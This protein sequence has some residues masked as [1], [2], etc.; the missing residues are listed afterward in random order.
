MLQHRR[1]YLS[2][3]ITASAHWLILLACSTPV[4]AAGMKFPYTA[5]TTVGD[6]AVHSGPGSRFY[7]TGSLKKAAVVEVH[8]HDPGGWYMIAPPNDSFSLIR[9]EHINK[10]AN[11]TGLVSENNVVV[12]VGSSLSP[13]RH[14]VEQRRLMKGD[15]VKIL[16]ETQIED[17]G[18]V[19]KMYKI[20][21]PRGEFRWV[22]GDY[23]IPGD[24]ELRKLHDSNPYSLPSTGVELEPKPDQ[25][26]TPDMSYPIAGG[27]S[28]P[29][30][31][32]L[33][34]ERPANNWDSKSA[35]VS[36][37]PNPAAL[38]KDR[39]ILDALDRN[40]R[41][42]IQQDISNWKLADLSHDYRKLQKS[43]SNEAI[44]HQIDLRLQAME[45]YRKMKSEFDDLAQLTSATNRRD[46]ELATLQKATVTAMSDGE[47]W[48]LDQANAVWDQF[49]SEQTAFLPDLGP[50]PSPSNGPSHS[51]NFP[52]A[53]ATGPGQHFPQTTAPHGHF[54]SQNPGVA[55]QTGPAEPQFAG[56]GI[57]QRNPNW[58][59]RGPSH[60]L[61]TPAGQMLAF[62]TAETGVNLDQYLGQPVGIHGDRQHL[63]A[64]REDLI[65]VSGLTAVRLAPAIR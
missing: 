46:A 37:V 63:P 4:V 8:R 56:A 10:D 29:R 38:E 13:D 49:E 3:M 48:D 21:P 36:S 57:V 9:A 18:R 35:V 50:D 15:R 30:E 12:R 64:H 52:P 39:S 2:R 16:G 55:Q 33:R 51:F 34:I 59:G 25:S 45:R 31:S 7:L 62:L 61:V 24:P 14:E 54:P 6:V 32:P 43:T 28:D 23:L 26:E 20:E 22:K 1:P 17:R 53:T 40:F 47:D 11:G 27:T 41:Q 58:T 65:V 5:S 19:V 42:M 44:A 60:I